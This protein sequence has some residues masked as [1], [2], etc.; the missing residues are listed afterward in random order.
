MVFGKIDLEFMEAIT[1]WVDKGD[2]VDI[3]YL[4]LSKAFDKVPHAR[5]MHK[6]RQCEIGGVLYDRIKE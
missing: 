5:L 4:D 6:L 2:P 3:T 1:E